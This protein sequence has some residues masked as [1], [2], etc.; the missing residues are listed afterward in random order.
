MGWRVKRVLRLSEGVE[1]DGH[2]ILGRL[3]PGKKG[4][5]V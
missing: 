1:G 4:I 2:G 3:E 5:F